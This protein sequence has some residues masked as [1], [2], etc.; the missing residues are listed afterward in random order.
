MN[1]IKRVVRPNEAADYLNMT[2]GMIYKKV[3]KG[4]LEAVSTAPLLIA[5]ESVQQCVLNKFPRVEELLQ[6]P[7]ANDNDGIQLEFDF[8]ETDHG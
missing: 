2:V 7:A 6:R 1:T 5:L 8:P 3:K 4:D